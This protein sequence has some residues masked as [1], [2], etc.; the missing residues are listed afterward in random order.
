MRKIYIFTLA[1]ILFMYLGIASCGEGDVYEIP[2]TPIESQNIKGSKWTL[3]NWDYSVGDDWI[4]LHDETYQFFFYSDTEGVFYYGKKD[5]YSDVGTSNQRIACHFKYYKSGK[6]IRLDYITDYVL[7]NTL[8]N[9]DGNKLRIGGFE[10]SKETISST[11]YQWLNTVHGQ[12]GSCA[13]YSDMNGKLWIVGNGSMAGYTSYSATPW[14]INNRTPNKVIVGDGVTT[15]GSYAFAN[16]SIIEV[17]MPD[18]SLQQVGSAAF[19]GS[20][21]QTIWL[22]QNTTIIEDNAFQNCL[23]LKQVN[24]PEKIA[25]IGNYA[26]S[27]TSLCVFSWDFGG[28]LRTIGKYAFEGGDV[29]Y[30]TFAEG[31]T[32]I[33]EGAFLGSYCGGNKELEL[34]NSLTTIA[35][36]TF[37]GT[38]NKIVVGEWVKSIGEA[39]FI[40]SASS[41]KMY[42]KRISPPNAGS[43]V[44]AKHTD[45]S[46]AES[47][48]TLYVPKGC[49]SAY[50]NKSPWNK[51][52][53]IIEDS[54]L[55]SAGIGDSDED[56]MN[57]NNEV[58][59]DYKSLSYINDGK[60]YKM[61]LVDGGSLSPFYIMQTELI[62]NESF[63]I[64]DKYIGVLDSNH[65]GCVT[66]GEFRTFR[67]KLIEVT[68]LDFRLPTT[69]EWKFAAQGGAKSKNYTYSGSNNINDVAWYSGN[70]GNASHDVAQ[71]TANELG[72]YDMSGNL[73]EV[74]NDREDD[75]YIVDGPIYGGCWNDVSSKCK[76]TSYKTGDTSANKIPG[77]NIRELNA[78]HGKYITVRLVYS[79]PE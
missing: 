45:W 16:P 37:A 50:A 64:G 60:T 14:A 36:T 66:K 77:T 67:D 63:Q 30:L 71:K 2:A 3:T 75:L 28:S 46:A 23:Y 74:C 43:C 15:I 68:G 58:L 1:A 69:A 29:S 24:M 53:S 56:N 59:V 34:P 38:F 5:H 73:G 61:V 25:Q 40:S 41:G 17:E 72:L 27:G 57:N 7:S 6:E 18:N 20:S 19:M 4:G 78:F 13:W 79:V 11:D 48:W 44:I 54:S 8:L 42:M 12:T 70:S 9:V 47:R 22:S 39:A 55:G 76:T 35:A 62:I 10:F 49:K 31:V 21:I 65:D 32:T 51:F 33:G 26:F 52:K